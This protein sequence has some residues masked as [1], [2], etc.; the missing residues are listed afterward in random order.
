MTFLNKQKENDN[1]TNN[2][3]KASF[4]QGPFSEDGIAI[5]KM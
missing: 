5:L 1:D 4:V 3:R 2:D